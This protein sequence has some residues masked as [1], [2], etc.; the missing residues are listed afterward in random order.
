MV[1]AGY[2][3]KKSG[4]GFYDYGTTPPSLSNLGL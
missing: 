2:Y 3:G 4:K 1:L